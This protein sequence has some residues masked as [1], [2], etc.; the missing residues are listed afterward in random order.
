MKIAPAMKSPERKGKP[1]G[2]PGLANPDAQEA[3]VVLQTHPA[4]G[5][6]VCNGRDRLPITTRAGADCQD[7]ITQRQT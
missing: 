6:K 7:Q 4:A 3:P 5:E 1:S 2:G